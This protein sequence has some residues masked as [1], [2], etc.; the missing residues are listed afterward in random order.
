MLVIRKSCAGLLFFLALIL[1]GCS[2]P[3][4]RALL[5]GER[6]INEGKPDKAIG[7]LQTATRLLPRNAQAWNHLGLAYHHQ[8]EFL[9]AR[10]AYVQAL[11]ID[12]NLA[13]ARYNLG[14][15]LLE[16]NDIPAAIDQLTSYTLL[17]PRSVDGWL[18]L[19][20]AQLRARRLDAAE[21]SFKTALDVVPNHP[22]ALN[23]LG[24]VQYHR[25]RTQEALTLFNRSLESDPSYAPAMLNVAVVTHQSLN[26]RPLAL[27]FYRKYLA[28]EPSSPN[29]TAVSAVANQLEQELNPAPLAVA[30]TNTPPPPIVVKTNPPAQVATPPRLGGGTPVLAKSPPPKPATAPATASTNPA[31]VKTAP[32]E[33]PVEVTRLPE[34]LTIKPAQDVAPKSPT[35]AKS[36]LLAQ[37]DEVTSNGKAQDKRG[38][39]ARLNPFS[40]KPKTNGSDLVV[41]AAQPPAEAPGS[42]FPKYRYQTSLRPVA[43]NRKEAER[44]FASGV[45]AQRS[46]N[47]RAALS[48]YQKS[49]ELDPAYFE[50]HYNR[51]L[52]AY[53]LSLWSD[54]LRAYEYALAIRPDSADARYNFA[55]A[56][57]NAGYMDDAVQQLSQ[58]LKTQPNE[59]RAHL[60]LA[61]LYAHRLNQP[62]LAHAHFT[63]VLEIDPR[64]PQ[65]SEIRFWL[66]SHPL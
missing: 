10:H 66:A 24:N 47:L 65:S 33:S 43:G 45:K 9:S 12:I 31:P 18:Q 39:L 38:L 54:S 6:L 2:D 29:A 11:N 7:A 1:A 61:N 64:H 28:H 13:A 35:P 56:L 44:H 8:S 15:L 25:R 53:E 3:G 32:K 59:A 23:G 40:G 63:K 26:N 37:S 17:Q 21:K 16:N 41:K 42:A 14:R 34:D 48:D 27:Q 58:L 36:N 52:A 20:S 60:S 46:G 51:G 49:V 19:G 57:K 62:K 22:E 50:A 55:L 4:T 5:K 30:A